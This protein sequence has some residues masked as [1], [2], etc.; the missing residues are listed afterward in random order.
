MGRSSESPL[1]SKSTS[2]GRISNGKT[3][4]RSSMV[5][6][7]LRK[8][9]PLTKHSTTKKKNKLLESPKATRI[10]A[11]SAPR[12]QN[13]LQLRK[14]HQRQ[15]DVDNTFDS[16]AKNKKHVVEDEDNRSNPVTSSDEDDSD[17]DEH[18]WLDG[19]TLIAQY[20]E[21]NPETEEER[22]IALVE[23]LKI[24]FQ[25]KAHELQR[26]L[27]NGLASAIDDIRQAHIQV[28]QSVDASRGKGIVYFNSAC[29]KRHVEASHLQAELKDDL[30]CG[31]AEI[32]KLLVQLKQAHDARAQLWVNLDAKIQELTDLQVGVLDQLEDNMARTVASLDKKYKAMLKED[33]A[34]EKEKLLRGV[35]GKL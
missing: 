4:I 11:S 5:E 25:E 12:A 27:C 1:H 15:D 22:A 26:E 32:K 17:E 28:D 6:E 19:L 3:K 31:Q 24:P 35:L 8:R 34:K 2:R 7:L 20:G 14:H 23:Y 33:S 13:T 16:M 29:D 21:D 10:S 18:D 30:A 9:G